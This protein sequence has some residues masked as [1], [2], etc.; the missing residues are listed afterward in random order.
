MNYTI[1]SIGEKA[2]NHFWAM[3][4]NES[5]DPVLPAVSAVAKRTTKPEKFPGYAWR[6]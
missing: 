2:H 4:L 3:L 6:K 1:S 5:V